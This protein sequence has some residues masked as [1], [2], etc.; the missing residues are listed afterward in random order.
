MSQDKPNII[1]L[2]TDQQ[3]WDCIGTFNEH[4]HT[5][6]LD[7]L[8]AEGITF[9]D[10]V[11]QSPMCAPSRSSMMMGYYPSQLGVRTNYGG[12]FE[13][14]KLPS[15]P[16]PELMHRAGYQTAGFGKRI[17]TIARA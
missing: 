8:A 7:K 17:G 6:N 3:R 9:H 15:E 16:L 5:P 11:C 13:E 4:I 12:L 14:D 2:M 1:F 10:A